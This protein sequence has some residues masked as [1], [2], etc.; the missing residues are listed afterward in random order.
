MNEQEIFYVDTNIS[1]RVMHSSQSVA[2][3]I[4][5]RELVETLVHCAIH[6]SVNSLLLLVVQ[7]PVDDMQHACK[8]AGQCHKI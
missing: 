4:P 3:I 8:S 6:V 1:A 5:E 2:P 7:R